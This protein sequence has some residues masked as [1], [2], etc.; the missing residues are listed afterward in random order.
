MTANV[1]YTRAAQVAVCAVAADL[2]VNQGRTTSAVLLGVLGNLGLEFGRWIKKHV[3]DV[4]L[5]V[6]NKYTVLPNR[7]FNPADDEEALR[8]ALERVRSDYPKPYQAILEKEKIH[9]DAEA[10]TH[11]KKALKG[12]CC[13]GVASAIFSRIHPQGCPTIKE[14][15]K[16]MTNEDVFYF[17]IV[18]CLYPKEDRFAKND[19]LRSQ[20]L[21]EYFPIKASS[22]IY[23]ERLEQTR[24][25]VPPEE[26]VLGSLVFFNHILTF[27]YGSQGY[28]VY[29]PF[30]KGLFK[31]PSA[32]IFSQE[33]RRH[34]LFDI[35]WIAKGGLDSEEVDGLMNSY[36]IRFAIK[37]LKLASSLE[38]TEEMERR[39]QIADQMHFL[40][41]VRNAVV[42]R[43]PQELEK[44]LK[45]LEPYPKVCDR[46]YFSLWKKHSDSRLILK[47]DDRDYGRQVFLGNIE[48]R[49][50]PIDQDRLNRHRI[51]AIQKTEKTAASLI[52]KKK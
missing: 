15:A 18:H 46:L 37:P 20:I 50:K 47:K 8:K 30:M 51:V 23:L 5:E 34:A 6:H 14:S 13:H 43:K 44:A 3:I 38:M 10:F 39:N 49:C 52:S 35:P 48:G 24:Q 41:E 42:A 32:E 36:Y 45:A 12:G 9:S 28:Y 27:Q 4:V 1:S 40:D 19:P 7:R 21:S 25:Q 31:Y 17:Q 29:D 11:F 33:L 22:R 26:D 16:G 2:Y